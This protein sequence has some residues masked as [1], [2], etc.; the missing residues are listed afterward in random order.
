MG[1]WLVKQA[2]KHGERAAVFSLEMRR[3]DI[4]VRL[5]Q[6]ATGIDRTLWSPGVWSATDGKRLVRDVVTY[7]SAE[8]REEI[9]INA[10]YASDLHSVL[11]E[12]RLVIDQGVTFV[13]VDHLQLIRV[14]G[15]GDDQVAT[16]AEMVSESL[17]RIAI[18]R[19]VTIVGLSQLNR[20][21]SRERNRTPS[22]H[23]L[24]GGTSMESNPSIV[25]LLDHSRY[26]RDRDKPHL[27]R[28]WVVLAKNRMG[29]KDLEV[30][31][32]WDHAALTIEEPRPD[33]SIE[34]WPKHERAA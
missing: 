28:T 34:D 24:W 11:G 22:I 1:L 31:I 3:E 30:P 13:V 15:Y 25:L 5:Q 21:A 29:P 33:E 26:E 10:G 4:L 18:E 23:D 32:R 19:E 12:I 7:Q 14:D 2:A 9:I 16:R 27:A 20:F 8:L 6:G 17:R